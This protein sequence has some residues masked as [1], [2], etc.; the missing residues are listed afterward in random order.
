MRGVG[1]DRY[2]GLVRIREIQVPLEIEVENYDF[3][4]LP[5]VKVVDHKN[6][7]KISAHI[8]GDG[9]LCYADRTTF[10]LDRY[11]PD[12]SI[13]SCLEQVKKTLELLLYGN[14]SAEYMAEFVAYWNGHS[15]FLID[16]PKYIDAVILGHCKTNTDIEMC[17]GGASRHRLEEWARKVGYEFKELVQT[18]VMNTTQAIK[19]LPEKIDS[20]IDVTEW[21]RPQIDAPI[22][23]MDIAIGSENRIPSLLVAAPNGIFGFI[24]Q[25]TP[26][27]IHAHKKGGFRSHN[28]KNLWH[29]EAA[30][31][32]IWKFHCVP[33]SHSEV[34]ARNLDEVAQLSTRRIALIGCGAIGG[35]FARALVQL[36][37]GQDG[38]MLVV[39]GESLNPENI[40]RHI[41]GSRYWSQ[42]KAAALISYLKM[43]FPDA[44]LEFSGRPAQESFDRLKGYDFIIDATGD[45]QFSDAFNAFAL[46]EVKRNGKF[47]P[48]QFIMIFGN[49]L[50]AQSYIATWKENSAC[51]RCLRPETG[52][53]WRFSPIKSKSIETKFSI[54][55]C[56]RGTFTP[57]SVSAPMHAAALGAAHTAD[58]FSGDY[59]KD[60]R[61]IR[62][63]LSTTKD[64]AHKNISRSERCPACNIS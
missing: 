15:Y 50:A 56:S 20:L 62:I 16:D 5:S 22:S 45:E 31:S 34:T 21:L 51:Y 26:I 35:Y 27:I 46:D 55:P 12:E 64:I 10:L 43:D 17:I 38:V 33:A 59:S 11:L 29:K 6:L 58:F 28:I 37:A 30:K 32:K 25:A 53:G 18:R 63:D 1:R 8:S 48:T 42:N 52:K 14:A 57:Y 23:L 39:D 19:P 41:L 54:R 47:P 61:T 3:L 49:G 24:A 7:M 60:L 40:G 4:T 13:N 2:E 44:H 36:G 9:I